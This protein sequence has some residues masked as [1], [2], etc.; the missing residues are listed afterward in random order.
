[1]YKSCDGGHQR[2]CRQYSDHLLI[3]FLGTKSTIYK[4]CITVLHLEVH[5]KYK[6]DKSKSTHVAALLSDVTLL[7]INTDEILSLSHH[8]LCTYHIV[9]SSVFCLEGRAPPVG[10]SVNVRGHGMISMGRKDEKATHSF[11]VFLM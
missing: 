11:L 8:V 2:V 4:Y 6:R 3:T 7:D 1:M 10:H 5:L 9:E